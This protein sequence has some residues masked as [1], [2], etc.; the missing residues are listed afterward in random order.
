MAQQHWTCKITIDSFI[1]NL[2]FQTE[3]LL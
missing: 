2:C 3:S 1:K